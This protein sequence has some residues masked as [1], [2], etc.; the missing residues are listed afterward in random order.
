MNNN[1]VVANECGGS[2]QHWHIAYEKKVAL[3]NGMTVK[4]DQKRHNCFTTNILSQGI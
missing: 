1:Q 3:E 4:N 2:L